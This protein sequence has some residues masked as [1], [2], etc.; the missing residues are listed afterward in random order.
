[1]TRSMRTTC[2]PVRYS[3][4]CPTRTVGTFWYCL[5]GLAVEAEQPTR[6]EPRSHRIPNPVS[7]SSSTT[8]LASI[9][10][11]D[12]DGTTNV[13]SAS[14]GDLFKYDSTSTNW[15]KQSAVGGDADLKGQR[16]ASITFGSSPGLPAV[17][18][19]RPRLLVAELDWIAARG[20]SAGLEVQHVG[21]GSGT[22]LLT[23]AAIYG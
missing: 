21:D 3:R 22:P 11:K 9:T 4:L 7:Y 16:I 20:V 17:P 8:R 15:V 10:A 6:L 13:T 14:R 2:Q 23:V 1:M 19:T 5:R 18:S 12:Y